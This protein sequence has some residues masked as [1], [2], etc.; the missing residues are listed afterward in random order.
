MSLDALWNALNDPQ[1]FEMQRREPKRQEKNPPSE[2]AESARNGHANATLQATRPIN[3]RRLIVAPEA[4]TADRSN[5]YAYFGRGRCPLWVEADIC[6]AKRHVRFTPN[7]DRESRHPQTAMSALP[8]KA[9]MCSALADVCFGPKA[10]I[11]VR[12]ASL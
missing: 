9:D 6:I 2:A 5:F 11:P 10:D 3:S 12:L 7:S 8:P 1:R 4:W